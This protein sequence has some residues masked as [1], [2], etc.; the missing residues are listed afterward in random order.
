[1]RSRRVRAQ[2]C[3]IAP[4]RALVRPSL[5]G[6]R[7]SERPMDRLSIPTAFTA[8]AL[9]GTAACSGRSLCDSFADGAPAPPRK[10]ASNDARGGALGPSSDTSVAASRAISEADIVQLDDEQ[11]R[12]YAMSKSGTLA[13]VVAARPG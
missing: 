5:E 12:I 6:G 13:I 3:G 9:F 7:R 10:E 1:A 4:D 2:A 8:L 11:D